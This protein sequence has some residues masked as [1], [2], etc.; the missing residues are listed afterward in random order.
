ESSLYAVKPAAHRVVAF[1]RLGHHRLVKLSFEAADGAATLLTRWVPGES[2][3]R[4]AA[5]EVAR[6]DAARP[7]LPH[8]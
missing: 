7:A 4:V 6:V 8:R 5:L 1:A 2:G 3:W